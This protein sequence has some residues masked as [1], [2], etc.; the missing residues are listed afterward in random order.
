MRTDAERVAP[1]PTQAATFDTPS[2]SAS[3]IA[4][5]S[6]P[7]RSDEH[8]GVDRIAVVEPRERLGEERPAAQPGERLRPVAAEPF[9]PTGGDQHGPDAQGRT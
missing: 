4:G 8:D 9:T 1:P 5:S 2:S 3:R 6:Q 7:D